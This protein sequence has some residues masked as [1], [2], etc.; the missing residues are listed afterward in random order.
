MPSSVSL[1]PALTKWFAIA[2]IRQAGGATPKVLFSS[3]QITQW[4]IMTIIIIDYSLVL[5]QRK[6]KVSTSAWFVECVFV[7]QCHA[8]RSYLSISFCR[9]WVSSLLSLWFMVKRRHWPK[10]VYIRYKVVKLRGRKRNT[11]THTQKAHFKPR[12]SLCTYS[13]RRSHRR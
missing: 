1:S 5:P 3:D 8:P 13:R 10:D 12:T 2:K 6:K 9:F 11:H 7:L 4:R